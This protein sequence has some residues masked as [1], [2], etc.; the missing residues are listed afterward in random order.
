MAVSVNELGTLLRD[1]ESL[2]KRLRKINPTAELAINAEGIFG[3]A[4][5]KVKKNT[6]EFM[7]M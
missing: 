7:R 6:W 5:Y 2:D 4:T 3:N 1:L